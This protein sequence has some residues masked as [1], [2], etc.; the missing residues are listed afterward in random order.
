DPAGNISLDVPVAVDEQGT[1]TG[2]G[3]IIAGALRQA[4]VGALTSPL[5]MLGAVGSGLGGLLGGGDGVPAIASAPGATEP[6]DGQGERYEG[7]VRVLAERPQLAL[8]LHGRTGDADRPFVAQQILAE[9]LAADEG[10]P[11][12]P[13]GAG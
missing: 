9:R 2:I 13:D 4:L 8:R 7:L 5:K 10:L 12:I 11:E 1:S 3:S 6:E